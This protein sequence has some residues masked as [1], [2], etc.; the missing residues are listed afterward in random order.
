MTKKQ[1]QEA[2]K[3]LPD[4]GRAV[5]FGR[6][7]K[8][9]GVTVAFLGS[10][11]VLSKA[12]VLFAA[13]N[14]EQI[15]RGGYEAFADLAVNF[16]NA[17]FYGGIGVALLAAGKLC[18]DYQSYRDKKATKAASKLLKIKTEK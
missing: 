5:F 12:A 10:G 15:E 1:E 2:I 17:I 14:S 7:L 13:Q 6:M 4:K 9:V 18:R 16:H 11:F 8:K 3:D